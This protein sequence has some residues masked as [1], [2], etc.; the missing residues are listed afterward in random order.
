MLFKSNLITQGS[1]SIGGV[2]VSRNRGGMYFRARAVPTN[3]NTPQQQAVRNNFGIL[4]AGW[5]LLSAANRALWSVYAANT[6]VI[7]ALG[8]TIYLTGQQMYIRCNAV[9]LQAGLTAV[10][11]GPTTFGMSTLT[12]SVPQWVDAGTQKWDVT[13]AATDQWAATTGGAL[14]GFVSPPVPEATTSYKGPYR[15]AGKIL[16]NTA[17]PPTGVKSFDLP[18]AVVDNQIVFTRLVATTSDGRLTPDYREGPI[19]VDTV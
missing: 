17:T 6:P 10:S 14:I 11:A 4:S 7:N 15:Y 12:Q 9:R 16:G 5:S 1:G 18:Y 3:P 2:T 8:D 19:L 13:V